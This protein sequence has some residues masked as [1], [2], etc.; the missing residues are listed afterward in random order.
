V[1]ADSIPGVLS[2]TGPLAA[3]DYTGNGA[4]D[5]FV[6]GRF[7]PDQYPR[8]ATSRLFRNQ[9]G[10]LAED[11]VNAPLF[12]DL[13]LVTSAL[14]ID[15]NRSGEQDLVMTT[16]WGTVRLFENNG[17]E[18]TER[19][20]GLGLEGYTGWWQGIATGDFT[21]NGYPDLVV[22][23]WGENSPYQIGKSGKPLR[24]FYGDFN[25][26][27][28]ID[29][30]DSYYEESVG[31]YVPRRQA[32]EYESIMDVIYHIATD[33]EFATSSVEEI[34]R[35]G[36]QAAI[37]NVGHQGLHLRRGPHVVH[38]PAVAERRPP[39]GEQDVRVARLLALPDGVRHVFRGDELRLLDVDDPAVPRG[40]LGGRLHQVGLPR[41]ERRDLDDLADGGG[42]CGL[43]GF[44]DVGRH[45]QPRFFADAGK[46]LQALLQPRPAEAMDARAVRLVEAR[47]EDER[48]V[49]P[50]RRLGQPPGR[51]EH[52]LLALDDARSG[53]KQQRL[54]ATAA[55]VSN[56]D[57][58][59]GHAVVLGELSVVSCQW[60]V[61]SG[62][63]VECT[64]S[65]M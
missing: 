25:W 32:S 58:I 28:T 56:R 57:G 36:M 48:H 42:R 27:G 60:S 8:N 35:I 64:R 38:Q 4:V 65:S 15:Y 20:A 55:G 14:F 49:E 13:G 24:M 18:F 29:I 51:V 45:R 41:E 33:R 17:G 21:G 1:A 53:D 22:T 3:A 10:R 63:V 19:T 23:N 61:I 44:V 40:R 11:I 2:T 47:L 6:G 43:G 9:D 16:E 59:D 26:N 54:A 5:L 62:P 7:L 30:M 52:E 50:G 31:G 37:D 12:E 34:L 39:L 46:D